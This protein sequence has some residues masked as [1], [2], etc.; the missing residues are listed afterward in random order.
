[1]TT[2]IK[3]PI[4]E[5][6]D[7]NEVMKKTCIEL[8]NPGQIVIEAKMRECNKC[9]EILLDEKEAPLFAKKLGILIKHEEKSR[10]IEIR[11]GDILV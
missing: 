6:G 8:P 9:G 5:I 11:E 10:R 3:C 4:C 2:N 1:M 7:L